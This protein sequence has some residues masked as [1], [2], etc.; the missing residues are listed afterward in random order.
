MTEK[1]VVYLGDRIA[2]HFSRRDADH[3][4]FSYSREW[5]S[6]WR[7]V[8]AHQIS[9]S[10]LVSAPDVKLDATA[11]VAG[12][13]PDSA[14]HRTLIAEELGIGDDPSDFAF[15]SRIGRDSAGALMVLPEDQDVDRGADGIATSGFDV[16]QASGRASR[17]NCS[18]RYKLT[19]SR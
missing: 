2:G 6:A 18:M 5:V 15:L 11:F 14:R 3:I 9:V 1:L 8:Q 17:L 16:S 10:L 19:S 7:D 13:L 12:L 4:D